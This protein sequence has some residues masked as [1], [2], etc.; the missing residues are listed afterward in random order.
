MLI[1][2][3]DSACKG[4]REGITGISLSGNIVPHIWFH[5]LLRPCGKSDTTAIAILSELMFFYR[6]NGNIEFQLGFN[7][8]K[9]KF[10]FGFDQVRD[11]IVRLEQASLV[12]RSLRSITISGR[13]FNNEM[14]L[15]LQ[16]ENVLKLTGG[17]AKKFPLH[18]GNGGSGSAGNSEDKIDK[19]ERKKKSR[20]NESSFLEKSS[21]QEIKDEVK[22]Q[23]AEFAGAKSA[24]LTLNQAAVIAVQAESTHITRNSSP[25]SPYSSQ[26]E[27]PRVPSNAKPFLPKWLLGKAL[28]EF[29]PLSE[30]DAGILQTRSGRDFELNFINQLLLR[31]SGK[32]PDRKFSSKKSVLNYMS[33]L[34]A[35]ELRDAVKVN[36]SQFKF[37]NNDAAAIA[38]KQQEKYLEQVE[39]SSNT[40]QLSQLRRKIA[41]VF[42]SELAYGLLHD[43][44]I[45]VTEAGECVVGFASYQLQLTDQ[46]REVLLGQ[47]AA[48]YGADI[49]LSLQYQGQN[50]QT[51]QSITA[52]SSGANQPINVVT[53]TE[54]SSVWDKV[55][56]MLINYFR[57]GEHLD[58]A[59][60]SK[61]VVKEDA[62]QQQITLIAPTNLMR[63]WI[64][65]HY[66]QLIRQYCSMENY[67]LMTVAV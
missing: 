2:Q 30:E 14:F 6:R 48:V 45:K 53:A 10:N 9:E 15:I 65:N 37:K 17:Q 38:L 64:Q 32:Y 11:A 47:I 8:F 19:K 28:A 31:V 62:E 34:L 49:T 40:D 4:A 23:S 3:K 25:V 22:S 26:T 12:L 58:Q 42:A 59:W 7:Y 27:S 1:A 43:A 67:Q 50:K 55:R 21:F 44:S 35:Y 24:S 56:K 66:G 33:K 16:P 39:N 54:Q 61:L 60:F 41:G 52:A 46:Q 51:N 5:Q 57:D 29:H 36:N 18:F 20:S 63:D 13:R